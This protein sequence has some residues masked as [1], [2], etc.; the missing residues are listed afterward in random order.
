MISVII[1]ALNE[2]LGIRNTISSIPLK[3]IRDTFGYDVEILVI[4]GN[5]TDQTRDVARKAGAQVIVEKQRGY[6]R[7]YK[8]GFAAARGDIIVTLDADNTYPA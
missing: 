4:D 6:G 7:A 2:E 5:S 1:P 8:T 3:E